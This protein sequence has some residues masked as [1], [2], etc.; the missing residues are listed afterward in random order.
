MGWLLPTANDQ[1]WSEEAEEK[2][3][4]EMFVEERR[5][6]YLKLEQEPG[7]GVHVSPSRSRGSGVHPQAHSACVPGLSQI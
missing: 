7:M 6:G 1:Y 2:M 4:Q 3:E 5:M